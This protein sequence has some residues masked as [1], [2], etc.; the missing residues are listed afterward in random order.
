M[1]EVE[2]HVPQD[3]ALDSWAHTLQRIDLERQKEREIEVTGRGVRRKAAAVFAKA[4]TVFPQV[5]NYLHAA[6][7]LLMSA[8]VSISK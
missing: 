3:Q 1:E 6:I 2:D 4:A 5:N 7:S 8:R